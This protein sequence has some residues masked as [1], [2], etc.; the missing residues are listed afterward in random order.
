MNDKF[1][2]IINKLDNKTLQWYSYP[3]VP[4]K[5]SFVTLGRLIEIKGPPEILEI[6][7]MTNEEINKFIP[8]LIE[9]FDNPEKD[10]AANFVLYAITSR[11]AVTEQFYYNREKWKGMK[12]EFDVHMLKRWWEKNK[13]N[14]AW[15]K[16]TWSSRGYSL[17]PKEETSPKNK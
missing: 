2:K 9:A 4:P 7:K 14:L 8:F 3:P 11:D 13:G 1:K 17:R 5:G 6:L 12:K 16:D 15:E 10:W